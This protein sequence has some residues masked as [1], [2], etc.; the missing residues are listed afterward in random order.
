[1]KAFFIILVAAT[2]AGF[3]AFGTYY[4]WHKPGEME[5]AGLDELEW[6]RR[7]FDLTEAQME[8][9]A[10]LHGEYR[11]VC[12]ELCD[13]VIAARKRLEASLLRADSMTPELEADL[14]HFSE[15]KEKCQRYMLEHV[16]AVAEILPAEQRERYLARAAVQ[17]TLHE[18]RGR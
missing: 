12:D 1:M 6:F 7:E 17:I 13:Q 18:P 4:S 9:M 3:G 15:V 10:V 2:A 11:P 16:F 5:A 14:A 8:R